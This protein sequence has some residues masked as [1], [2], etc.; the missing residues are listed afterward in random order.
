MHW[1]ITGFKI[2]L[3]VV[4]V[5]DADKQTGAASSSTV[6]VIDDVRCHVVNQTDRG[7]KGVRVFLLW[8][9]DNQTDQ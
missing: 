2:W 9:S 3:S 5:L 6:T 4:Y 1:V 7:I 8:G